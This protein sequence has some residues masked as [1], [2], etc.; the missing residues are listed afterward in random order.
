MNKGDHM[1]RAKPEEMGFSSERLGRIAPVMQAYVDSNKLPGMISMVAR[2]GKLVHFEKFGW[3]DA[4]KPMQFDALF[5]IYSM[6]KPITSTA[7]M[8]LFEEGRFR[9]SD[10]VCEYLPMFKNMQVIQCKPNGDYAFVP[11]RRPITIR[12]L[13]TH[14]SGLSYGFDD[15]SIIDDLYRRKVWHKQERNPDITLDEMIKAVADQPLAYH[16]G[17]AY[18]YSMAIDVLGYLVQVVSGKPFEVFLKERIF[19]PLRMVDTSFA[20]PAEKLFR[21]TATYGPAKEGGIKI[22][23]APAESRFARPTNCPSGGGGL[24][25]TADDYL[26]FAQMLM[27]YGELQGERLLGRKTVELMTINHL[28]EGIYC[29]EDKSNGFGLGFSVV[30]DVAASQQ[31]GSVGT[32]SWGGAANTKFII[33]PEEQ[34]ITVLM[35]QYMPGFVLPVDVDFNNAVY[36]A[37][38]D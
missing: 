3:M 14:S 18:R 10:P 29:F 1:E 37:L 20:V 38:V 36:Q 6:T 8:M 32:Y 11:A 30:L 22:I 35:L 23:D 9:L 5:R 24:I 28:P 13:F 26:R 16:P 15:K 2:C 12:D 25:S 34:L 17:E 31:Q 21:F 33:D 7:V 27:N 4:N 19:D